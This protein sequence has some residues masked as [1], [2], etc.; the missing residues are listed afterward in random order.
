MNRNEM[1]TG[2]YNTEVASRLR[3]LAAMVES[4]D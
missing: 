3:G 2:E 4:C 1:E